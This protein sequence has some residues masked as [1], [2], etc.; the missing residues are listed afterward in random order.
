MAKATPKDL[1]VRKQALL[2]E[3]DAIVSDKKNR[4]SYAPGEVPFTVEACRQLHSIWRSVLLIDRA[5]L[6]LGI[7]DLNASRVRA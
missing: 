6:R 2:R 4:V 3:R 1:M 7:S 5:L